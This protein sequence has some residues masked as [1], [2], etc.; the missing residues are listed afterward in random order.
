MNSANSSRMF[1]YY[2]GQ[3]SKIIEVESFLCG[4]GLPLHTVRIAL[5][6]K[7]K[8]QI[9]HYFFNVKK[10]TKILNSKVVGSAYFEIKKYTFKQ[11]I[12]TFKEQQEPIGLERNK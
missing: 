9:F 6:G 8:V 10:L 5:Y 7:I 11:F 12:D 3:I 4:Y 1:K 2:G